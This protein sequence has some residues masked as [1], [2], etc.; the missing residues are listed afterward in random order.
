MGRERAATVTQTSEIDKTLH[1]G[2]LRDL[3]EI[4]CS[5]TVLLLKGS[6]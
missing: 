1:T 2:L 6:G 3:A 4:A 5:P